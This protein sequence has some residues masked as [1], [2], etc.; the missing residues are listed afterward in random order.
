MT[1][2]DPIAGVLAVGA[3]RQVATSARPDAP[4]VPDAPIAAS[5]LTRTRALTGPHPA[6]ARPPGRAAPA[7]ER[8][9]PDRMIS[10]GPGA[11]VSLVGDTGRAMGKVTL[12]SIADRVG[13]S[14]MTV[15]NAFSRP[16][17]L[18]ADLRERILAAADEVGYVGPD[19]AARALARG[20]TGS[21]GLLL[22][23]RLGEAF[24][25]AVATEFLA[26]VADGL[27]AEGLALTLITADAGAGFVP[28]RDVAMDGALIYLCDPVSADVGWLDKRALPIVTVDQ[29]PRPGVPSVN[30]DDHGGATAAAEHL[31]GLGH[32]RIGVV[33][34][35]ESTVPDEPGRQ[36]PGQERLRGWTEA[37]AAA[38]VEPTVVSVPSA[39]QRPPSTRPSGCSTDPT[40]PPACCAS[41]TRSPPRSSGPRSPSTCGSPTTSR[42]S[43]STT[44]RS[45]R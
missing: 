44:A 17:Q 9:L 10:A 36:H 16:D 8:H 26:A 19:P 45:R 25:D 33:T 31:L 21:I 14:R 7:Y 40:A 5:R 35:A 6:R 39:R 27:A 4:V 22:T 20:R 12:Q 24:Q 32:R 1:S 29:Y 41:P 15:S 38:G 28:A 37:L 13:V 23:D 2:F 11:P 43:A 34:I 30:V 18:S 42:W 3:A